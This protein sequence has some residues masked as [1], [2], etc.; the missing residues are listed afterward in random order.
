MK[1]NEEEK[2]VKCNNCR[3][4][5]PES[6]MF[7]HEGFCL[8][9]NKF[10]PQCEKVFLVSE[11]EEHI[12]TH[13]ASNSPQQESKP[14]PTLPEKSTVTNQ[15][16]NNSISEHRKNCMHEHKEPVPKVSKKST[17]KE[18]ERPKIKAVVVDDSLGLKKC[19]YCCN[20]VEDLEKHLLDCE[21]KKM[22]EAEGAKYY[23]DLEKRN[24]EDDLLAQKLAKEKEMDVSKDEWVAK[25]LEKN[26]KP[27]I[28]TSKDEG[29]AKNL[30]K[31]LGPMIDTTNDEKMAR[32]LQNQ[33]GNLYVNTS[34]DEELARKL[35]QQER[36]NNKANMN[37]NNNN[38]NMDDDLRRAIEESKKS[39]YK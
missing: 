33:L 27:I 4:N 38:E 5:I 3:Q 20:V 23:K 22:I 21:I 37:Q 34:N 13:N 24:K 35:E 32:D 11:Y 17:K 30:Q 25:N 26:L 10:C 31:E 36:E 12:K 9:N 1:S 14:A 28:D 16:K 39:I 19:E 6:K 2:Y 8:R 15:N 7:L 18:E 29:I